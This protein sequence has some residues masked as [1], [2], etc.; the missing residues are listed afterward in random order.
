MADKVSQLDSETVYVITG[1]AGSIVSAITADLAVAGAG[2]FYLL[3]LAPAPDPENAD[4]RRVVTDREALKREIFAS[5]CVIPVSGPPRRW[6]KSRLQYWSGPA[7]RW[8]R[9]NRFNVAGGTPVYRQLDLTD[10]A[11]VAAVIEEIRDEHGHLDVLLH[12]AGLEISHPLPDKPAQE[13]DLVFD[14]KCDGWF[15]L[16]NA[17]GDMPLGAAVVFSS[18]A[19]RFGNMGQTDYS[20][21]NDL[22]CKWISAMRT[23]HPAT[24]GIAI[25]WTAWAD[26]G[27]ASRGS[28][29]QIMAMA[30]IDMLA[31]AAGIPVIR[32]ELTAGSRRGELLVAERLGVLL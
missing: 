14:V 16:L 9:S 31:P 12:A 15:N 21:A 23:T 4:I 7:P 29:P 13:F 1:A 28:I 19:G 8:R 18:I 24:R 30:G 17:I 25:D 2:T 22:M 20:A 11:A 3:D 32:R 10:T 26:I 27:M 5:T 6:W